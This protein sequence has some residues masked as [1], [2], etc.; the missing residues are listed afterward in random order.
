MTFNGEIVEADK[1]NDS[2]D[3]NDGDERYAGHY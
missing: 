1:D 2:D 3:N